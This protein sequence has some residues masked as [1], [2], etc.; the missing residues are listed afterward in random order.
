MV[1]QKIPTFQEVKDWV[2]NNADVPSANY[3]NSAGDTDTLDGYD[4]PLPSD[5]LSITKYTDAEASSA[6][7]V[8]DVNGKTGSVNLNVDHPNSTQQ[9]SASEYWMDVNGEI[10][11]NLTRGPDSGS[12][13]NNFSFP[14]A[15]RGIK[16]DLAVGG[17]E[18]GRAIDV[19]LETIEVKKPD[20]STQ[21]VLNNP[22]SV[23]DAYDPQTDYYYNQTQYFSADLITGIKMYAETTG[24][25]DGR[26][27]GAEMT[28][29]QVLVCPLPPHSHSI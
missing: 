8:Q 16:Y 22:I 18:D 29:I 28:N 27:T 3:A 4:T 12:M 9:A 19:T 20:G 24:N 11:L 21:N 25:N 17:G 2:N 10:D 5:A 7:P 1:L 6:A 13:S 14:Y 26:Y 23:Y 15:I